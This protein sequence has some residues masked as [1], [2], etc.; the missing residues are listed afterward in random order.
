[1]EYMNIIFWFEKNTI[2]NSF[3][4]LDCFLAIPSLAAVEEAVKHP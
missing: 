1:M 4:L 3:K 2:I